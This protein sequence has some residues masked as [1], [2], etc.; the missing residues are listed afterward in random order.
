MTDITAMAVSAKK[1]SIDMAVLTDD[2]K[3]RALEAVCN[4]LLENESGIVD[5]NHKDLEN[6]KQ[7]DLAAPQA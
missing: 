3:N 6:A 5:A 4:A 7:A 1:A 2:V